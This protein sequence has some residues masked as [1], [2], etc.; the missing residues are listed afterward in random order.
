M[1]VLE[2]TAISKSIVRYQYAPSPKMSTY[3]LAFVVGEFDF[4]EKV[5][6]TIAFCCI[7][8]TIGV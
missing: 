1:P 3:L 7:N 2:E 4:V 6:P 5:R 8:G